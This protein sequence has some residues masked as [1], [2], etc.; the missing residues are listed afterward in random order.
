MITQRKE[1]EIDDLLKLM[2]A[3]PKTNTD[4]TLDEPAKKNSNWKTKTTGKISNRG[5]VN[6]T[7]GK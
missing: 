3:L 5:R 2:S 6:R 7:R 4:N 1:N